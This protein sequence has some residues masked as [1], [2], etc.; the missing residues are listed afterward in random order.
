MSILGLVIEKEVRSKMPYKNQVEKNAYNRRWMKDNPEIK[1]SHARKAWTASA[2]KRAI[3]KAVSILREAKARERIAELENQIAIERLSIR[4][5]PFPKNRKREIREAEARR[6]RPE[7]CE[8]CGLAPGT[9]IIG[10]T[11]GRQSVVMDTLCF[12][13]DYQVGCFRGWLCRRCNLIVHK[14]VTPDILEACA[15][16]LRWHG[17]GNHDEKEYQKLHKSENLPYMIT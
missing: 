2:I 14:N 1:W 8:I 7:C 6:P 13:H 9:T 16:Y 17:T 15:A 11:K 3:R 4:K 10:S 12:D 5:K